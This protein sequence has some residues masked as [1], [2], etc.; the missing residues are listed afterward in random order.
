MPVYSWEC[1]NCRIRRHLVAHIPRLTSHLD[2]RCKKC[3]K[4]MHHLFWGGLVAGNLDNTIPSIIQRNKQADSVYRAYEDYKR[5]TTDYKHKVNRWRYKRDKEAW[6]K[7]QKT[8][9]GPIK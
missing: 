9:K 2:V 4:R 8:Y 6:S 1:P 7:G 3:G 5:G